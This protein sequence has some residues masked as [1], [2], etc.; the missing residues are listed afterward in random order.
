VRDANV[1]D[2]LRKLCIQLKT[3]AMCGDGQDLVEYAL[4][5][6]LISLGATAGLRTGGTAVS[7]IVS[8]ISSTLTA[9]AAV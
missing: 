8:K 2:V 5:I 4:V 7:T 6:G 9:A 3:V 1:K